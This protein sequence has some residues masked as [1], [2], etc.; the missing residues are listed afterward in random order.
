MGFGGQFRIRLNSWLSTEW[1]AD[2]IKTDLGGLGHRETGH[3]GW[4]V[5]FYPMMAPLGGLGFKP[6]FL[7]GHC[8]DF[9][10]ING[11]E[12]SGSAKFKN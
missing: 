6:Y 2:H 5:M 7:A 3:I 1:F 11:Y 4:S 12:H 9:A 10:K 8:F